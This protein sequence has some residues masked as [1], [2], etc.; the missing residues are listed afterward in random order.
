MTITARYPLARH[1]SASAGARAASRVLDDGVAGRKQPVAFR[2]LHHRQRHPVLHGTCRIP[3][4]QLH[5]QLRAVSWCAPTEAEQRR[6]S[7]RRQDRLHTAIVSGRPGQSN[8]PSRTAASH[9][10]SRRLHPARAGACFGTEP[11]RLAVPGSNGR[12]PACKGEH[13]GGRSASEAEPPRWAVPGSNGR[14]PACKA[15]A[16]CCGLLP[17]V[18]QTASDR[19]LPAQLLPFAALCCFQ[20]ASISALLAPKPANALASLG[21][22]EVSDPEPTVTALSLSPRDA[23]LCCGPPSP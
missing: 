20:G 22:A 11:L 18:A 3:I 5:P 17:P 14:P 6:L 23:F 2:T 13:D 4:L 15:R 12:P 1:T 19:R 21:P 8:G 16:I 7:D 10:G 9:K